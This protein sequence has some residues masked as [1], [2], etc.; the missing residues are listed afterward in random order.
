MKAKKIN[1]KALAITGLATM[2]VSLFALTAAHAG[3][4]SSSQSS[5]L[6]EQALERQ[7]IRE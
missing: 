1:F 3:D 4:S 6:A 7:N 5:S 2:C